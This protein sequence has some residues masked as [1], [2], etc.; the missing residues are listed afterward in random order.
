LVANGISKPATSVTAGARQLDNTMAEPTTDNTATATV[1]SHQSSGKE[2]FCDFLLSPA[3]IPFSRP[4]PQPQPTGAVSPDFDSNIHDFLAATAELDV[5]MS[6]SV[7]VNPGRPHVEASVASECGRAVVSKDSSQVS[8][9]HEADTMGSKEQLDLPPVRGPSLGLSLSNSF[10]SLGPMP[11]LPGGTIDFD[12]WDRTNDIYNR[13]FAISPRQ[14]SDARAMDSGVLFKVVKFGWDSLTLG[15]QS[16]P[17]IH[18]LRGY[19]ELISSRL[20]P[21]NRL[22]IAYK[23]HYLIKVRF[24]FQSFRSHALGDAD[25]NSTFSTATL[26]IWSGCHAGNGLGKQHTTVAWSLCLASSCLADFLSLQR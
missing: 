7:T 10:F 21:L 3:E 12:L 4:Q 2:P 15:E 17:V 25:S 16:N 1:I 14:A 26:M 8:P 18:I 19:D 24:R 11:F 5:L 23:N 6:E 9:A 20:D 13:I 22:A